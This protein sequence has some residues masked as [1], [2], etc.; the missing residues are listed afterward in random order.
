MKGVSWQTYKTLMSEVGDER[1]WRIAYDRGILEIRIP[2]EE[3]E[4]P[5]GLLES[6]VKRSIFSFLSKLC[7]RI[8]RDFQWLPT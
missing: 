2:L 7:S 6:F 1:S 5:K 8:F 4:E 3:H